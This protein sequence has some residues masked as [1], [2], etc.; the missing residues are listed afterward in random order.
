MQEGRPITSMGKEISTIVAEHL[1]TQALR[2]KPA[3]AADQLWARVLTSDE[4]D[5]LGGDLERAWR[6]LG[7]A[8][9]WRKL[10]RVSAERAVIDV[11]VALNH[12][13]EPTAKWLLREIGEAEGETPSFSPGRPS[14]DPERGELRLGSDL[15][16]HV[17]IFARPTNV[18][19]ILNAFQAAG[20]PARIDNPI[21][22]CVD[23]QRL[24]QAVRSLNEGLNGIGFH[25]QEGGKAVT[26][27]L[28]QKS[29]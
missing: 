14:W 5:R 7:T 2:V 4:R 13:D 23:Q 16:R 22:R 3:I 12:L 19:L 20:W 28:I 25:V 9:I 1:T 17:R 8:G 11:A 15:I 6:E 27:Q 21:S 29:K 24:H 10:H 18:Q 26:W